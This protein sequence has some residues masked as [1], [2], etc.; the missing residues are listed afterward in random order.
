MLF[1][2]FFHILFTAHYIINSK[3]SHLVVD[4]GVVVEGVVADLSRGSRGT[5]LT[6][7]PCKFLMVS[8]FVCN[9]CNLML[10]RERRLFDEPRPPVLR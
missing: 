5:P 1:E 9:C 2:I 3:G 7:L 10:R 6:P 8:I 4:E